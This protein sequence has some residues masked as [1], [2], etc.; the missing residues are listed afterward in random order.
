MY[1]SG[2]SKNCELELSYILAELFSKCL[3]ES[4]FPDCWKVLS[5][6]PVFK[7]V[8]ER[9][10][11]K[12]YR[13]VSLLSVVSKVFEKLVNNRIVDHLEKCGLFSDF[14]YGFRSSRS[15]AD[16]LTVVSDR[17]AGAFNRSGAT[18]AVAL[19]ISKA[20]DRVLHAGLLHKLKSYGISGQI[21]SLISSFLS[22]RQLEVV[23]DRK[24]SQEYPVNA[25]VPQG[26]I[27]GPTLFLL[28][29]NDL[30][31]D[32]ICDIAIY[33][34]D[35]TLYS[36]CDRASDLWQQ[37]ELASEL[38]S[39]LRDMVDWGKKWLVDFNAG[40]TQL[41]PFDR[42]NNNGSIDVKMGGSILEEKSSFK[43]LG[44]TFSSKLDW[45]SYIISIAKTASK[46]IG[47]LICSMKFLSPE[48]APYLYKSTIRACME[49]CCQI[50]AGAP[51]CY[52]DLLDKLQKRICRIVGPSLA[53]SLEPLA[54]Y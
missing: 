52:L 40:K 31:D 54:H 5:V 51:S 17:I 50:W 4:S 32:V 35:T 48:V 41:V 15:T 46:K 21:F 34:D 27:L 11:A 33:A 16:L 18:R 2:G 38:E 49:Y 8:G 47:A 43:M 25:G 23:L 20:F 14:Q 3:K 13:P 53:P 37:L 12:N 39:D 28:Y 36:R 45:G 6:V 9:S 26:S 30:P 42:P 29:S 19:D 24:S 22:N 7:N 44:L 10:T 1:S